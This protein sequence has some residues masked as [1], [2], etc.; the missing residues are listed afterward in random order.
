M[1]V[2]LYRDRTKK[3]GIIDLLAFYNAEMGKYCLN[4]YIVFSVK[5]SESLFLCVRYSYYKDN[6]HNMTFTRENEMY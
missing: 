3:G 6:S 5:Y 1:Q 4:L 2:R